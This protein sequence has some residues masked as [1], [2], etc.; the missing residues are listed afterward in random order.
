MRD[1][2]KFEWGKTLFGC[3]D[4]EDENPVQRMNRIETINYYIFIIK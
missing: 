4:V 2:W 3:R 1:A